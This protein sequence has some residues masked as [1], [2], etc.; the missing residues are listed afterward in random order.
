MLRLLKCWNKWDPVYI[1]EQCA[2][3]FFGGNKEKAQEYFTKFLNSISVSDHMK[4]DGGEN[5]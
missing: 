4:E 3:M 1:R 5:F 2:E